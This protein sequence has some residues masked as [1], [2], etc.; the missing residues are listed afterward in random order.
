MLGQKRNTH[1]CGATRLDAFASTLCVLT[2]AG[3]D[4]GVP[5]R[6][7]YC[8][9]QLA[10]RC[11]FDPSAH[12]ALHQPAVLYAATNEL[13][14][15]SSSVSTIKTHLCAR[16]KQKRTVWE[17]LTEKNPSTDYLLQALR[18]YPA[19]HSF[20]V[21]RHPVQTQGTNGISD[22]SPCRPKCRLC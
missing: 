5:L 3:I 11:P 1:F 2:Y 13:T 19:K 9:F 8:F 18:P 16:V 22:S 21:S 14:Y 12:T 17:I 15:T 20:L 10:L 7:T 6:L 4:H